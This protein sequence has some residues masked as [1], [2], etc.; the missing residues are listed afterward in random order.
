MA[1]GLLSGKMTRERLTA[2]PD[3]DW[4][5]RSNNFKEPRLTRNL[6]LADLL[7]K[8]GRKYNTT[9]GEVA[10]AWTLL[11]PAV[12]GAIVGLRQPDQVDGVINAGNLNLSQNDQD[13][14][15]TFLEENP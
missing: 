4:R 5:K 9:A 1:S 10:I 7:K 12:T 15:N 6:E 14:I 8:I 13:E 11:N 2:L 3:D